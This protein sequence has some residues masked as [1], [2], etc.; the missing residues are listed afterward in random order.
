MATAAA[1]GRHG[2]DERGRRVDTGGIGAGKRRAGRLAGIIAKA[3]WR[4]GRER[5]C[6]ARL[7]C[8]ASA[9]RISRSAQ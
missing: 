8:Y 4:D 9:A 3:M 7:E 2:A 6:G 5:G 1:I